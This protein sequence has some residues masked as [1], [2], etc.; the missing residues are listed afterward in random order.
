[1]KCNVWFRYTWPAV[2]T[3]GTK[4][5]L[6]VDPGQLIRS[7]E[8]FGSSGHSLVRG[9]V[10]RSRVGARV[11]GISS[12]RGLLCF[13]LGAIAMVFFGLPTSSPSEP[14]GGG[15]CLQLSLVQCLVLGPRFRHR[16]SVTFAG[17]VST[18]TFSV[19]AWPPKIQSP[20]GFC[21]SAF[22]LNQEG[23]AGATRD[24]SMRPRQ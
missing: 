14:R 24:M 15:C 1:M 12:C 23:T 2:A 3:S 9:C 21:P 19:E 5:G 4:R 20:T 17:H 18:Q 11:W 8:E 22:G 16:D 10:R 6:K 13:P 7:Q